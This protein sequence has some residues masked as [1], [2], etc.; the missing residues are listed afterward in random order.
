MST[1]INGLNP[2]TEEGRTFSP[3]SRWLNPIVELLE[4][5]EEQ[6]A[7][8]QDVDWI[9]E[10]YIGWLYNTAPPLEDAHCQQLADLVDTA[11][12]SGEARAW[13]R[14]NGHI[15]RPEGDEVTY[16]IKSPCFL[17]SEDLV[18]KLVSFL[19]NCGGFEVS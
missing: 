16:H 15:C 14:A 19:R 5:L 6:R 3:S 7:Q 12:K 18:R 11:L 10:N 4:H 17:F 9:Y 2:R 13:A 8:E 1:S